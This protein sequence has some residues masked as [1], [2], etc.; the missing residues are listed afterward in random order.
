MLMLIQM[1]TVLKPKIIEKRKVV[2]LP[3][4]APIQMENASLAQ[5]SFAQKPKMSSQI[6]PMMRKVKI[7]TMLVKAGS[8]TTNVSHS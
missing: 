3:K 8:P 4:T 5:K 2:Q 1:E 6:K 7:N